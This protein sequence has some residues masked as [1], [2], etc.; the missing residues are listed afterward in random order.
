[1]LDKDKLPRHVAIIMDGNGRWAREKGLPRVSGHREG[2]KRVR[3]VIESAANFG[4]EAITLFAFSSENWDRPKKEI[5]ALMR[6]LN[7]FLIREVDKMHKKNIRFR[8]I[9]RDEPL[10]AEI[11]KKIRAA[12]EK[13]M[14]NTGMTVVLALNYGSRQE[15]IDAAAKF[16]ELVLKGKALPQDLDEKTFAGCLYAPDI[17]DPDLLIRTSG[18]IRLSNF[19]L[20][21]LSYAEFYFTSKYWPDFGL[22]DF[23]SALRDYQRRQ[24]RFGNIDAA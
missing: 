2:I 6:Y 23:E 7:E 21:Q 22:S 12:E 24:R 20:W 5:D 14:G 18:E 10:P 1:M 4:L 19:L 15:I 9:G 17:I 3:E 16:A 13:T 11:I 8:S